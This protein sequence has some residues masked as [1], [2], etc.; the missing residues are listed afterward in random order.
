MATSQKNSTKHSSSK[1]A[2]RAR[3]NEDD[4]FMRELLR[5]GR[6]AADLRKKNGTTG[7]PNT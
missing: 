2:V 1:L 6:E 4:A 5:A 7:T 3:V